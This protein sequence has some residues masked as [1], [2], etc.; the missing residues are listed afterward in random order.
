MEEN[1]SA[2]KKLDLDGYLAKLIPGSG[3]KI[4]LL[5]PYKN[6]KTQ[7][8]IT[9]ACGCVRKGSIRMMTEY[10]GEEESGYSCKRCARTKR[11]EEGRSEKKIEDSKKRFE[12]GVEGVDYVI[13]AICGFH[14]KSLG[15]HVSS[16]HNVPADEYRKKHK[17]ICENSVE[18]YSK[19]NESNGDWI[20]RAQAAG[21]DL[22]EYSEKMSQAVSDS[23]MSN[24]EE[25]E[26]RSQLRGE[27]NRS[28]HMRK[29]ASET[30]K[31]TSSRPEILEA[32]AKV[33]KEWREENPDDFY[34][35]CVYNL[36]SK[37]SSEEESILG[38]KIME[39]CNIDLFPSVVIEGFEHNKV[40]K[41]VVDLANSE[42]NLYIEYDGNLHFD[43]SHPGYE[44]ICATDSYMNNFAADKGYIF[45]R[46]S[47]DQFNSNYERFG[48]A[49]FSK[50]LISRIKDI[51]TDGKAGCYY[52]GL[53]YGS[54]NSL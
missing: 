53:A 43:P 23:I 54:K 31:K 16:V 10:V 29:I 45:I 42:L 36:V 8:N 41:K 5:E 46:V 32:R 6:S 18:T 37:G 28:D 44:K 17:I 7:V 9:Y 47:H 26:R 12:G 4:D 30:A 2:K 33:L 1:I 24:P 40:G 22:S 11:A 21:E 48:S 27:I 51:V 3:V 35:K 50:A 19:Q 15:N 20:A 14:A 52:L 25:R 34:N 49:P 13:C 38:A 39:A